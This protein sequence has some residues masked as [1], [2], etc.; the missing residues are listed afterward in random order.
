MDWL[1][2]KKTKVSVRN[3]FGEYTNL[4]LGIILITFDKETCQRADEVFE[5]YDNKLSI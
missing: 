5:R 4:L 2:F 3:T 1:L